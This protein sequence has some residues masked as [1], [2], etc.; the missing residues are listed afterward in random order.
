M[1]IVYFSSTTENTKRF[2]DKLGYRSKRIPL[3]P[4]QE[5]HL[6][7]DEPFVLVCPTYGGGVSLTRAT[8]KPVPSQVIKF[9]NDPDNRK[10]LRAVI[11]GGNSNFGADYGKAG[12]LI[13]AKCNVPYVYRFELMG[14]AEDVELVRQ[15]LDNNAQRLGLVEDLAS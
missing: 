11:S 14:T 10:H 3:R 2:V 6:S 12:D 5:G 9:L 4:A 13:A 7:V 15:G 8:A 1:L